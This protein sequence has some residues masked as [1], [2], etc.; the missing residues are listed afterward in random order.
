[1]S[2]KSMMGQVIYCTKNVQIF[3]QSVINQNRKDSSVLIVSNK[4][5]SVYQKV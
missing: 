1:M 4:S 3:G 2:I 5:N